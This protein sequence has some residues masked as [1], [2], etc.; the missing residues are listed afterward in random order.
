MTSPAPF[1][2]TPEIALIRARWAGVS[3]ASDHAA[4]FQAFHDRVE[5]L[6]AIDMETVEFDFLRPLD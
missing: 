4:I 5:R 2:M 1:R 6:Y 3:A